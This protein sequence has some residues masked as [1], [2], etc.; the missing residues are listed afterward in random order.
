MPQVRGLYAITP[1]TGDTAALVKKVRQVIAGG[2]RVVQYRSKASD[3]ELRRSQARALQSVCRACNVPLV[4]NDD[5]E[6]ALAI[7]AEGVHLGRDDGDLRA[8]RRALGPARVLGAS[9]YNRL[10]WA[11]LALAQGADHVAFGSVYGSPTKPHAVRAPLELFRQARAR[12][13]APIIAIGGITPANAADLIAAGAD[14][15]AVISALFDAP[16]SEAAARQFAVL[17]GKEP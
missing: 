4:I 6:L 9:C 8:A 2:A 3:A 7:G 16:D 10:E 13:A 11:E 12:L 5:V 15:V 1:E 14:A 17:F